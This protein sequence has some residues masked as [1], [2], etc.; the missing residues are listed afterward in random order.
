MQSS[1]T[2]QVL[3]FPV[4][5]HNFYHSPHGPKK[6]FSLDKARA[7]LHGQEAV[8]TSPHRPLPD[9]RSMSQGLSIKGSPT[10]VVYSAIFESVELWKQAI[11]IPGSH[12]SSQRSH[13]I[14]IFIKKSSQNGALSTFLIFISK[15]FWCQ[16]T[17]PVTPK[18]CD[19]WYSVLNNE[20]FLDVIS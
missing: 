10:Y 8:W 16:I 12:K 15:C 11:S 13:I 19:A 20:L 6:T 7:L 2:G 14:C 17:S 4:P 1:L 9:L 5:N 18:I 3:P